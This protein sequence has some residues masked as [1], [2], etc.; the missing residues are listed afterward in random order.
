MKHFK[1]ILLF[2]VLL[3][4]LLG[5]ALNTE[6]ERKLEVNYPFIIGLSDPPRT[7][8]SPLEGY[9]QYA[10]NLSIFLS[11][12]F[13]FGAFVFNGVKVLISVG[14]PSALGEAN[15]NL[16]HAF[17]G[18][19]L[20]LGSFMLSKTVNPQI[21]EI[22]PG[23]TAVG[24]VT[25]YESH[26]CTV[27]ADDQEANATYNIANIQET[28]GFDQKV[29]SL[30]FGQGTEDLDIRAYQNNEYGGN[31]ILLRKGMDGGML[32]N[33]DCYSLPYFYSIGSIN[34]IKF[35]WNIPGIYLCNGN[36]KEEH[37]SFS[38]DGKERHLSYSSGLL[39]S[40]IENNLK[41]LKFVSGKFVISPS[42]GGNYGE[43][44]CNMIEGAADQRCKQD[45]GG[46]GT[47]YENNKCYCYNTQYGAVLHEEPNWAGSCEVISSIVSHNKEFI[48][49]LTDW[50]T[51]INPLTNKEPSFNLTK[52]SSLTNFMPASE[53]GAGGVWFCEDED[54][55][56]QPVNERK[57][58]G[59]FKNVIETF[60]EGVFND[61]PN[62]ENCTT[63]R[64][65][66]TS[67]IIDGNYMVAL[68]SEDNLK[69]ECEV[70]KETVSDLRTHPL[71]S[72]CKV[73]GNIGRAD[74]A[75]SAIVLPIRG[76]KSATGWTPE[77]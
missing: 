65:G 63:K 19:L 8:R 13:A 32:G 69:G 44:E 11:G 28:F 40:D 9:L 34:S 45:F 2:T 33:E 73:I 3:L 1:K 41:G 74:C 64:K 6:A 57:C 53:P 70:F 62:A 15:K 67:I 7:V 14:N 29:K 30:K 31:S 27:S 38:C 39:D 4:V 77:E 58:Y 37:S 35:N 5:I 66:I 12:I 10:F 16:L 36:Y 24:G 51:D 68:F 72:C 43:F 18:I 59:P 42:Q 49:D 52:T 61:V 23:V 60:E 47:R 46:S 17:L 21:I 71:G 20:I 50:T 75:S 26:D 25:L 76:A 48:R 22:E 54:P 55:K 56:R